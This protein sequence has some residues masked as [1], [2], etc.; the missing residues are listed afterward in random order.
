MSGDFL[1]FRRDRRW[2]CVQPLRGREGRQRA[3]YGRF[4]SRIQQ[5]RAKKIVILLT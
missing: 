5:R 4:G 3:V 2:H 1:A